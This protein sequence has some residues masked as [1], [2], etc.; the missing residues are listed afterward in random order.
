MSDITFDDCVCDAC[1]EDPCRCVAPPACWACGET[2]DDE[3]QIRAGHAWCERC[4]SALDR[5]VSR[6]HDCGEFDA[7]TGHMDCQYPGGAS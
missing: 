1:R 5:G 4:A 6:C 2:I 7:L 3:P